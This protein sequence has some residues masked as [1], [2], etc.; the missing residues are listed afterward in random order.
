MLSKTERVKTQGA[1]LET[2][3]SLIHFFNNT[4]TSFQE[5][6]NARH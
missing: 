2:A 4:L 3:P 6:P 1:A 5:I